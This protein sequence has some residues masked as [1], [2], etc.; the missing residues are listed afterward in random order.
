METIKEEVF[1]MYNTSKKGYVLI[2][3][4]PFR[5]Y[6]LNKD[7]VYK[8]GVT[9]MDSLIEQG[10]NTFN[11]QRIQEVVVDDYNAVVEYY[12]I[13]DTSVFGV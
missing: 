5:G 7:I 1:Y 11:S 10:Y 2:G 9:Q 8:Y 6:V 12:L 4:F 13:S 3:K